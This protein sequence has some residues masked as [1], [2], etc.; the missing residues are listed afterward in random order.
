MPN[1][2]YF[3]KASDVIVYTENLFPILYSVCPKTISNALH[4]ERDT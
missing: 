4:S 1:D 2:Y 3:L